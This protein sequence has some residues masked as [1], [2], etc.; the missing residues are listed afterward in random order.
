MH[1]RNSTASWGM[2][3][4]SLSIGIHEGIERGGQGAGTNT[5]CNLYRES[6]AALARMKYFGAYA[7]GAS[8]PGTSKRTLHGEGAPLCASEGG[9]DNRKE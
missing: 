5:A 3:S 8:K 9:A 4:A 7:A 6:C 1:K 2:Q